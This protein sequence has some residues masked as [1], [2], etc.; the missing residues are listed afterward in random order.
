VSQKIT[1]HSSV[2]R[3]D[4]GRHS[5]SSTRGLYLYV[6]PG[7]Q[8]RR[9]IFR[10]TAPAS[11]KVTEKGL[12]LFPAVSL[13]P[14]QDKVLTLRKQ[15]AAGICPIS[16]RRTERANRTSFKEACEQWIANQ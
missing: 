12:G 8:V 15:I 9:W 5:V 7:G 2:L 4:A 3:A 14:A 1:H 11:G 13:S 6:T 10:F 16:A